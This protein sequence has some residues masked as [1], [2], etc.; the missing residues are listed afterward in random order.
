[1]NEIRNML[2]EMA[3]T[4]QSPS[5][6]MNRMPRAATPA[7]SLSSSTLNKLAFFRQQ[8][9]KEIESLKRRAHDY[10]L[11]SG[12]GSSSSSSSSK[13]NDSDLSQLKQAVKSGMERL[14]RDKSQLLRE[15]REAG[16]LVGRNNDTVPGF[17][18]VITISPPLIL[19]RAQA[20]EIV[21]AI[22][23]CLARL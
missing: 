22:D 16:V 17:C 1:M 10:E 13:K 5:P 12:L 2:R 4:P 19:T 6:H 15:I 14:E 21:S 8:V 11:S 23:G 9:D 7:D 18:N 20:D 3:T